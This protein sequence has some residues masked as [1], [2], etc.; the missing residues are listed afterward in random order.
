MV[1]REHWLP[2]LYTTRIELDK[3]RKR[4]KSNWEGSLM[5]VEEALSFS[6]QST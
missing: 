4:G 2:N 1:W 6:K 5:V 3:K